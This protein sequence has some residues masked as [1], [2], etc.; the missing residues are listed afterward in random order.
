MLGRAVATIVWSSAAR[1]MPTIS[2][3]M[4]TMI[5]RWLNEA[6]LPLDSPAG[7]PLDTTVNLPRRP[8]NPPPAE[9]RRRVDDDDRTGRVGEHA[10]RDQRV[11]HAAEEAL[12]V[13]ADDDHVDV[14]V[15]RRGDDPLDRLADLPE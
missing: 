7:S 5:W 3:P 12:V 2:P 1:K 13:R 11:D 9:S 14:V 8:H 4:T 15:L 10:F 6:G